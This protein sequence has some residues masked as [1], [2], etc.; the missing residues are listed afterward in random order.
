MTRLDWEREYSID[1]VQDIITRWQVQN[2]WV[3]LG[4]GNIDNII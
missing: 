1:K 3:I 4:K 2:S